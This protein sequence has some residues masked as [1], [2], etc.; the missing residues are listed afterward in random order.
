MNE[1]KKKRR[2]VNVREENRNT[3]RLIIRMPHDTADRF[4]ALREAW[5]EPRKLPLTMAEV[6]E[7]LLDR[8]GA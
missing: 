7:G 4:S 1:P 5:R 6:L 8:C 2:T 3:V